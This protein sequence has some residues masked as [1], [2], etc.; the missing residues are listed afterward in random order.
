MNPFIFISHSAKEDAANELLT[1]LETG[2]TALGWDVFVDRE[3]LT[4][5]AEWRDQLHT[6]LGVCDAAVILFSK[7]AYDD[8]EWV[9][10]EATIFG[11]RRALDPEFR[12]IPVVFPEISRRALSSGR[13]S[14]VALGEL[15]PIAASDQ[16]VVQL[17][18]QAL[19]PSLSGRSPVDRIQRAITGRLQRVPAADLQSAAARL[20]HRLPWSAKL[21]QQDRLARDLL[22]CD[23]SRVRDA[24]SEISTFLTGRE[25]REIVNLLVP[26]TV[27][28]LAVASIPKVALEQRPGRRPALA[29]N[30]R[31]EATGERY[32]QRARCHPDAWT[33][34][35]LANAGG[36]DDAGSLRNELLR[37]MRD[38]YPDL[39]SLSAEEIAETLEYLLREGTPVFV[40]IHGPVE[41]AT[42]RLL[43]SEFRAC[44]F[45]VLAGDQCDEQQLASAGVQLLTPRLDNAREKLTAT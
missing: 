20:G 2:L 39:A 17:I 16:N 5:G 35:K 18:H 31:S 41:A 24:L 26:F 12:V 36:H 6:A 30:T 13:Y 25:L 42:L 4:P 9:L 21:Q 43:R 27:D 33:V 29:V 19:E 45:L 7:A 10:K 1:R 8:S 37:A 15:T 14:P 32:V 40:L 34:F 11:W 28:P 22:H 3:R 38:Q 23:L 44:T